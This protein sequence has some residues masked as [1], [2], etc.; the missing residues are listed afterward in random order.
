MN[1][2]KL[3][4]KKIIFLF[5]LIIL[6]LSIYLIIN[7]YNNN[8]KLEK[9]ELFDSNNPNDFKTLSNLGLIDNVEKYT[10]KDPQLNMYRGQGNGYV[11]KENNKSRKNKI[12][13]DPHDLSYKDD[14]DGIFEFDKKSKEINNTQKK[15]HL[16]IDH[17]KVDPFNKTWFIK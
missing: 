7:Y 1:C 17:N 13:I 11:I 12:I 14:I 16:N 9:R 5:L 10:I 4:F 2:K 15:Y 3:N 8:R 6:L